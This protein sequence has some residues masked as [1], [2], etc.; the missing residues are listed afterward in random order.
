MKLAFFETTPEEQEF[1][2]LQMAGA[3]EL[4][5]VFFAENLNEQNLGQIKDVEG[6]V[7]FIYSKVSKEIIDSLPNLKLIATRSTGFDHIDLAYAKEKNITVCNVPSYG[8]RTVAEFAFTLIL[9]LSRRL[10]VAA[11]QVKEGKGFNYQN[12]EGF[13]LQGKTIGIIGTGRIGLNVA[14]IA[15]GF[16][17]NIL[18]FEPHPKEEIAKQYGIKYLPLNELLANSDVISIHVPYMPSTHHLINKDN[19]HQIKK[20]ALLINTA[21]GEVVET[22]S[23]LTAL[24]EGMLA[25]A[26]LDV[27]EGERQLKDETTLLAHYSNNTQHPDATEMVTLLE[28]HIL[29]NMPNVIITPHIAFFTKE[30][31]QEI[32][33]TTLENVL[34][35]KQGAIKNTVK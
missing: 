4:E 34:A 20:N 1:L 10:F 8:S 25:G 33:K 19:I 35:F 13:N 26:G 14:Q 11:D 7:V 23:L 30:A 3:P 28:D 5:P 17:M 18:G 31:K 15:K 21:R 24:Q 9:S 29:I 16:D 22:Q 2:K 32:L 6:L 27:L 12:F